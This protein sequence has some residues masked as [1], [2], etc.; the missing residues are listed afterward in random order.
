L[1]YSAKRRPGHLAAEKNLGITG[2]TSAKKEP[3][4]PHGRATLVVAN[5]L[6]ACG[7]PP[8]YVV[9]S[10]PAPD[11]RPHVD[12]RL[13]PADAAV[14]LLP[15]AGGILLAIRLEER[16]GH[17]PLSDLDQQQ[18]LVAQPVLGAEL[19]DSLEERHPQTTDA[20]RT[21]EP[22]TPGPGRVRYEKR[23]KNDPQRAEIDA[24]RFDRV[25]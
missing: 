7:F 20:H 12:R 25:N 21:Q 2:R 3:D 19:S 24:Q 15:T 13:T 14:V 18:E 22:S 5:D 16:R 11:R 9:L 6:E 10:W 8:R 4:H 1:A 23:R 17:F